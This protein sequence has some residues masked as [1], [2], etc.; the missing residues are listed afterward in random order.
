MDELLKKLFPFVTR[1]MLNF[2]TSAKLQVRIS[3]QSNNGLPVNVRLV[4]RDGISEF[5]HTT[6]GGGAITSSDFGITDIPIMISV[7]DP[8]GFRQ[9]DCYCTLE[10]LMNGEVVYA[11]TSGWVYSLKSISWPQSESFNAIP[12]RGRIKSVASANPT[13][14]EEINLVV[15]V[16]R[17]WRVLSCSAQLATG[18]DVATRTANFVFTLEDSGAERW[19]TAQVDQITALTRVYQLDHFGAPFTGVLGSRIYTNMPQDIWLNE[20]G[21]ISTNTTNLQASDNWG[22]LTVW[23]EEYF[24]VPE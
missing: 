5:S 20:G 22:P 11:F 16:G 4:T 8:G 14:E 12:D 15:P 3:T 7:V 1:D 10:L 17:T 21:S 19:V 6:Q 18:A 24:Q 23:I 2:G 9:G 13:L